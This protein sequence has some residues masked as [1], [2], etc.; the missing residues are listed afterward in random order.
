MAGKTKEERSQQAIK[1]AKE[2]LKRIPFDVQKDYYDTVLKPAADSAGMS[3][4]T[5]IKTAIIEKI[6]RDMPDM[7]KKLPDMPKKRVNRKEELTNTCREIFEQ[8][9]NEKISDIHSK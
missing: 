1:Y 2:H 5:F 6:E 9:W 8:L 7:A 3:M 4:N